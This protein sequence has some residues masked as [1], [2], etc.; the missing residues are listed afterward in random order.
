LIAT[1]EV[2]VSLTVEADVALEPLIEELRAFAT[3]SVV[4]DRA[5][6]AVVG[7]R[8]KATPGLAGK[9]F[10]ALGDLNVEMISMGATEINLSL[11]VAA[12]DAARALA[13]LHRV[14]MAEPLLAGSPS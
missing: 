2:S 12:G 14:L 1:A 4:R 3:V 11:V 5:L 13:Q 9:L 10:G 6:V 8:L 7:E